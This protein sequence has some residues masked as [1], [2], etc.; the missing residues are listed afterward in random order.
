VTATFAALSDS[1]TVTVTPGPPKTAAVSPAAPPTIEEGSKQKFT[2]E[3]KDAFGNVV[4]ASSMTITWSVDSSIGTMAQDGT[5]TAT[6]AGS[7][8]V[9]AEASTAK[10]TATGSAPVTVKAKPG[11]GGGGGG[12]G[13]VADFLSS[14][15]GMILLVLVV[16]AAGGIAAVMMM[17]RRKRPQPGMQPWDQ[18]NPASETYQGWQQ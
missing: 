17:K 9:V 18:Q 3:V 8:K 11:G 14:P 6:K 16:A 10:G 4:P 7:G 12:S 2:V 13:S 5:F 1:A 15:T